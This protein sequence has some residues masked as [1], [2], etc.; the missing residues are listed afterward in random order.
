MRSFLFTLALAALSSPLAEA[1]YNVTV[2][3]SAA[4]RAQVYYAQSTNPAQAKQ[5][6]KARCEAAERRACPASLCE[7]AFQPTRVSDLPAGERAALKKRLAAIEREANQKMA[8]ARQTNDSSLWGYIDGLKRRQREEEI[9]KALEYFR[10]CQ[11]SR[12][13]PGR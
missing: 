8:R 7:K 6:A 3:G 5:A 4:S 12:G 2:C 11:G 9:T 10:E 1:G 13:C